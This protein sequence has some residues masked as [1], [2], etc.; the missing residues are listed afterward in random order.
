MPDRGLMFPKKN[1][2]VAKA[3]TK[4][5]A[6][7]R[8]KEIREYKAEKIKLAEEKQERMNKVAMGSAKEAIRQ[9]YEGNR[10]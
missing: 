9:L 3:I 1:P 8:A 5:K 4:R 6:L 7:A 2:R 10:P